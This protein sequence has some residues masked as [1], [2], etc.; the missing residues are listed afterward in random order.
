MQMDIA[1]FTMSI[2]ESMGEL[3]KTRSAKDQKRALV[4]LMS[5]SGNITQ[6]DIAN[7]TIAK[8]LKQVQYSDALIEQSLIKIGM[9]LTAMFAEYFLMIK[10]QMQRVSP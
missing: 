7:D 8:F 10:G 2:N 3:L 4:R 9:K 1:N 5:V 6:T